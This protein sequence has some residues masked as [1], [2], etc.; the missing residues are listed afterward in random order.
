MVT[1]SLLQ[2]AATPAWVGPTVAIS[3]I[4]M[5]GLAWAN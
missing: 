2:A 1:L 4:V 3:L 5:A